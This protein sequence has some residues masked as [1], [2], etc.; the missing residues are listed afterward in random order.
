MIPNE[1]YELQ[2]AFDSLGGGAIIC[3]VVLFAIVVFFL[4]RI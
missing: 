2:E 4:V 1:G 3:L